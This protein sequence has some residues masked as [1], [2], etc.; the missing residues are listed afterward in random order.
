MAA[1]LFT[2]LAEANISVDMIIQS[3]RCRIN[4]GTPC[5][6]IAFMVAEGD[7]NQA[8]AIL[9]PLI[10]DWLDAAVVV[11]KAIAKVSIVG[12]GMIEPSGGSGP[13]LCRPSPGKYQYRND[14][15]VGN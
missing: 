9:Q 12:S 6:D 1:Q 15:H 11:N 10:K 13:L 8:E 4:Q 2:A 5:R 14:C 3:Q 7:S